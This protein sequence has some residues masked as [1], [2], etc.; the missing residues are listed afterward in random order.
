MNV[1]LNPPK[2][3]KNILILTDNCSACLQLLKAI[4]PSMPNLSQTRFTLLHSCP[5]AYWEHGGSHQPESEQ[6]FEMVWD[7][8]ES[9]FRTTDWYFEQATKILTGA[10]VQGHHISTVKDPDHDD[11]LAATMAEISHHTYSGVI[12][13]N[14]H[15]DI[16]SR[17]ERR[18]FTDAFRKIPEI[19]V[20]AI[21]DAL[22]QRIGIENKS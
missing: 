16:I 5:P 10:G 18:G 9:E 17:L 4:L 11:L 1:P 8:A 14:R 13:N 15:T 22:L 6:E 21:D 2:L 19:T 3:G 20:W 12:L 7:S